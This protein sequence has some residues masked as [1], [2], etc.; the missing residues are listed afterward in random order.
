MSN[1]IVENLNEAYVSQIKKKYDDRFNAVAKVD[2]TFDDAKA[3]KLGILLENT[4][5]AF[6]RSNAMF[7]STQ[8]SS[9][10]DGLEEYVF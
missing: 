10:A 5:E 1:I 8:P 2:S 9:V 4:E 6:R 7:E 3:L